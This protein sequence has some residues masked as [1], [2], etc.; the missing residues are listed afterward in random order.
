MRLT[1]TGIANNIDQSVVGRI[2]T[3]PLADRSETIIVTTALTGLDGYRGIVTTNQDRVTS[4][5][6]IPAIYAVRE[7]EHLHDGDIVAMHTRGLVRTLFINGS[8]HNVLFVTERC[9]SNCLMCSQPPRDRED[10][11][12]LIRLNHELIDL[13]PRDTPH[14]VITG[15]EPTLLGDD[16]IRLIEHLRNRLPCTCICVLTNAR[17]FARPDYTARFAG[18]QHPNLVVGVPL[19]SDSSTSHD[20][21]VQ[22]R[23]AFD[24]TITGVHHLARWNFSVEIRLV[25]HRLTIPRLLKW[26]DFVYRNLPF[27]THVALMGMEPTGFARYHHDKLWI[28]P[29]EYQ[30]AL[31]DTVEFLSI[32]GMTVSV[33]NLQYC[34]LPRS[35]W[36]YAR[37]SISDWKRIFLPACDECARRGDCAGFFESTEPQH[38]RGVQA[39]PIGESAGNLGSRIPRIAE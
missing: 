31:A 33:Y 21:I 10:T 3:R 29:L 14:L 39:L 38:T 2:T 16:L 37:Q 1:T 9:N 23:G 32:R 7:I 30:G 36:P 26:A 22:S 12:A 17:Q 5:A 6:R 34:V 13:I 24:E 28:D 35:L 19:Y 8:K 15:G 4:T 20:Y 25:L 18:V 11:K 27:T